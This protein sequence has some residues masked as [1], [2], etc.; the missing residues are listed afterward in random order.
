MRRALCLVLLAAVVVGCGGANQTTQP[1]AGYLDAARRQYVQGLRELQRGNYPEATKH[2]T[3]VARSPRYFKYSALAALRIADC[4]F[5]QE[6]Y[7]QAIESY[8]GF[9]KQ[10]AGDK[11]VPY[12]LFRVA[13]CH[14]ERIPGDWWFMPPAEER[15]L[16][17][18]ENA[19]RAL[20]R[21]LQR[22]PHHLFA[23]Q[24]ERLRAFCAERLYDH[25]LYAA[26]FYEKRGK[27]LAVAGRLERAL[28]Q[29]PELARTEANLF[30]LTRAYVKAGDAPRARSACRRYLDT[31][32]GGPRRGDIERTLQTLEGEQATPGV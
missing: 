27:P 3:A 13:Q 15:D 18:V 16:P 21:F 20:Q 9:V 4:Q 17:V 30:W 31:F 5:Y 6:Q 26:K 10:F 28:E 29:F 12:A 2:F 19:Y 25:E 8:Q 24:A 32:P 23:P 22:Y 11:N 1:V 14:F 7:D